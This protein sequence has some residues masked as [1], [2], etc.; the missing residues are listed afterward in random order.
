MLLE[1]YQFKTEKYLSIDDREIIEKTE[2]YEERNNQ[3]DDAEL[4]KLYAAI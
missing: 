2:E 4:S 3:D 1:F